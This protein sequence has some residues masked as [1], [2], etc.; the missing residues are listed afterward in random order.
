[1]FQTNPK[2]TQSPEKEAWELFEVGSYEEVIELAKTHLESHFIAHLGF[3][4]SVE[5][6]IPPKENSNKGLSI[7]S[8]LVEAWLLQSENKI[9]EASKHIE[10]F[11]K[12]KNAIV[13]FSITKLCYHVLMKSGNYELA[14]V[15]LLMYRHKYKNPAFIKEEVL[16][17]Y[18]LE[19]YSEI[20]KLWKTYPNEFNDPEMYRI[21]GMALLLLGKCNDAESLFRKI[22]NKIQL[23]SFEDKKKE[24][25][26]IYKNIKELE[27]RR[28]YLS[29][30][31]M[32]DMGFA[33]LFH[34]EFEKA[35]SVFMELV[36][37][38]KQ[39]SYKVSSC[40]G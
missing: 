20:E 3:L 33:Y 30:R 16:V 37:R 39:Q 26:D 32:E 17:S 23:P 36:M 40:V 14:L 38:L 35:E 27:K 11:L 29:P 15:A 6:G 5:L 1:M 22:Q 28:S 25:T 18:K 34:S 24:Y 10:Y 8:P 7:F 13:C 21:I 9:Q 4:S 19:R 31:Q 2:K 12:N